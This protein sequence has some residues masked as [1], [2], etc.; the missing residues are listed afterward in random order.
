MLNLGDVVTF[1]AG[2]LVDRYGLPYHN[3]HVAFGKPQK[4]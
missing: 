1:L 2:F 4:E 3:L